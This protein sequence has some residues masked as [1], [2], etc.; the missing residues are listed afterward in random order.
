MKLNKN[1]FLFKYR[2]R[3]NKK[4]NIVIDIACLRC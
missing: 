4:D 1:E 2:K 3:K